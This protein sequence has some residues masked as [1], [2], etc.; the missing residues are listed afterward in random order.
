MA[1]IGFMPTRTSVLVRDPDGDAGTIPP[2]TRGS[3]G[4]MTAG[5]ARALQEVAGK[6]G[7]AVEMPATVEAPDVPSIARPAA[8]QPTA[9]EVSKADVAHVQ[10]QVDGVA[11]RVGQLRERVEQIEQRPVS[12]PL[13][14]PAVTERSVP[15]PSQEVMSRLDQVEQRVAAA[16]KRLVEQGGAAN[17]DGDDGSFPI[18]LGSTRIAAPPAAEPRSSPA[19]QIATED[20][21]RRLDTAERALSE[22]SSKATKAELAVSAVLGRLDRLE[23]P[24]PAAPAVPS[25]RLVEAAHLARNGQQQPIELM[26]QLGEA[27]GCDWNEAA[28]HIIREHEAALVAELSAYSEAMRAK[29]KSQA[30]G[31]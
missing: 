17:D 15:G 30:N 25:Y 11:V 29:T 5:M 22:L 14:P 27:M 31:G 26:T 13:P 1:E 6:M 3:A 4:V 21:L 9:P 28:L 8:V 23:T 7:V 20:V 12:V 19:Q 18:F 10:S 2:A 24:P 16:E